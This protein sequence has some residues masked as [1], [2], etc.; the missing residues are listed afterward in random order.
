M[1]RIRR[2]RSVAGSNPRTLLSSSTPN[3]QLPTSNSQPP[4]PSLQLPTSNSQPP[5]PNL[6]LPASNFQPPTPNLRL[7]TLKV[8]PRGEH[9]LGVGSWEL[10]VGNW[11]L[12][13]GSWEL[14]VCLDTSEL[15]NKS[16]TI[17]STS[18]RHSSGP[19][20]TPSSGLSHPG[21]HEAVRA[22][23]EVVQRIGTNA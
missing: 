15:R 7:P 22:G 1:T 14:G 10:E 18:A 20:P 19:S 4:T 6:Q 5:T 9:R 21:G 3:L 8:D 16:P 2:P 11:K 13:V 12:G 17:T 23:D